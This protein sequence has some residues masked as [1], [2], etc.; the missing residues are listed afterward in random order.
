MKEESVLHKIID[1]YMPYQEDQF[2]NI[3][4]Y[5][6]FNKIAVLSVNIYHFFQQDE[7]TNNY[8][9]SDDVSK[10]QKYIQ[11]KIWFNEDENIFVKV[12]DEKCFIEEQLMSEKLDDRI[13]VS[14]SI[15]T[16]IWFEENNDNQSLIEKFVLITNKL[17][18]SWFITKNI[19]FDLNKVL[20]DKWIIQDQKKI[21]SILESWKINNTIWIN[22]CV[23]VE[24][25]FWTMAYVILPKN[26]ILEK[27]EKLK[28]NDNSITVDKYFDLNSIELGINNEVLYKN[29]ENGDS[30]MFRK[31]NISEILEK[32]INIIKQL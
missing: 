23:D 20:N 9:T 5:N 25:D 2:I 31:Y 18:K 27:V 16:E 11:Q 10:L 15:L 13:Q 12:S 29:K 1:S 3:S 32:I 26:N 28:K 7:I 17:S 8:K 22:I 4:N 30:I 14:F 24:Y 21:L 6:Q 19:N